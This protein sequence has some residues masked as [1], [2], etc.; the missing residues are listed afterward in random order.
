[1]PCLWQL[2]YAPVRQEASSGSAVSLT[3]VIG[4]MTKRTRSKEFLS[5]MK[6]V[7]RS[8]SR[9]KDLHVILDNHSGHKTAE[10]KRVTGRESQ[11][12]LSLHSDQFIWVNAV[13]GWFA[14]LERR[15]LYRGVFTS[16]TELDNEIRRFIKTHNKQWAIPFQWTKD[17]NVILQSVE[18]AKNA[19]H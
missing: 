4:K 10:V 2:E 13:E 19:L 7:V 14:Q 15:A 11:G 8:T 12:P 5:F 17:A 1:M 6:K 9:N 18:R 16:V 3:N